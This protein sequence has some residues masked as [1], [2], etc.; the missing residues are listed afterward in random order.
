M[1]NNIGAWPIASVASKKH[2][3]LAS[4][5]TS[6]LPMRGSCATGARKLLAKEIDLSVQAKRDKIAANIAASN[7]FGAVADEWI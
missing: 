1:V 3:R 4:I 2:W 6:A 5:Q 7:T